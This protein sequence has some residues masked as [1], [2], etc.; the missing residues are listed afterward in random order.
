MKSTKALDLDAVK[1][2]VFI[3]DLQSF[4]RAAQSLATTQ[5]ALSLKL[6]R[7]EEQ[8]GRRLLERTPR[9]VRLSAEGSLFLEAARA[10]VGAHERAVSS[11]HVER[12]RLTVGISQL[13]V[14][15]ELPAL[16]RHMNEHDPHLLL[17]LRVGGSRELLQAYE[18]GAL[19]AIL[20]MQPESRRQEGEVIYAEQFA[21]IA[22]AHWQARPGE[23]LPLSTQGESCSIRAAAV[24]ALDQA[25][26]AW[27]EVFIGKGAAV[28]GAAAAAGLA[29][30]VLARRAA[31]G[32]TVDVGP[33]LSLP[34]LPRQDVA[35]YTGLNDR[36]SRQALQ[37]LAE[38]FKQLA[39]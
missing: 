18:E 28:L 23:P 32:G 6:R 15:S 3:A 24:R 21:W 14:G 35:L 20:V 7:L 22:A 39:G 38:A 17:E 8:L 16:L 5:S 26:I 13:I 11:F 37:T 10:L 9:Q 25:G 31:P 12:R 30:A 29:I 1:A 33:A 27:T 19:D 34:A 4:T 36:R 2:F